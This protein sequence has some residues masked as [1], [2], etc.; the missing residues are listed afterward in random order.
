MVHVDEPIRTAR[1][2]V[3]PYTA[4]DLD[5]VHGIQSLPEV[6]RYLPFGPR[7]RG[8]AA[9]QLARKVERGAVFAVEGDAL[10]LAVTRV[11]GAYVGEVLLFYRTAA[12]RGAELGYMLR[13]EA[14][15]HGYAT[16]AATALLD[17]AFRRA[18]LHRVYARLDPRNAPS[19]R[20]LERL[21]MRREG[22]LVASERL[23]GRWVDTLLYA[24]LAD[25]W[26]ARR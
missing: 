7:D 22:H 10:E 26:R 14:H 18:G 11:D 23:Q 6:T 12:H 2:V 3:R 8:E 25:E 5:H 1:L 9:A 20:V 24:V 16:E 21:G 15:G 19:V 13:P 4:A 17:F